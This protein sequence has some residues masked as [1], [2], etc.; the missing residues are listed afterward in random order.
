MP[1]SSPKTGL[2]DVEVIVVGAGP[3]GLMLA[4][5][6]CLAGVRPLVLERRAGPLETLRA[7]GFGGR[8]VQLLRYRGLLQQAGAASIGPIHTPARL[9]FGDLHVDFS[10]LSDPPM[11]G[12]RLPQHKLERL[13][14][15]HARHL[16]AE[17]RRGHEVVGLSRQSASVTAEVNGPAG[18]HRVSGRYLVGCDGAH[19]KVRVEAGISFPGTTYPQVNRL[20]Q[21]TMPKSVRLLDSGELDVPGLGRVRANFTRTDRGVFAIGP[22]SSQA[23]LIQT[24]EDEAAAVDDAAPMTLTEL[25]DSI[26]RVIGVDVPLGEPIRLSRYQFQARQAERY[27]DGRVLVA[28]DA[29]HVFPA[30]GVGISVGMLDAVNL[31]WK[32]AGKIH[33]WA[34]AGLL[35]S[36]HDE[37]HFAGARTMLHT[38]AQVALRRGT[39]SAADALRDLFLELLADEQPLRRIGA[40]I[41]GSDVCY[42]MRHSNDHALT[43]AFAPDLRLRTEHGATS[44]AVLMRAARPVFIDLADRSELRNTAREWLPR[45]DVHTARTVHRPADAM[46][47]RP[48]AHIAWAATLGEPA[49]TATV[50]LR[51][52]LCSWFGAPTRPV[53]VAGRG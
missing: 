41:A 34:P 47:I 38:Q 29:A 40:L 24:T 3:T 50:G 20:G 31:A 2:H 32:L 42:R 6:L 43:G 52:A 22:L 11:Q 53:Q 1:E 44:V 19:S 15:E 28:G 16:G 9:P 51:E 46:L 25:R 39:D 49:D 35:D 12:L 18:L 7:N 23:L 30:T 17:V 26:L 33:G 13:L 37:R 48:D 36:Y 5:E 4:A 10:P 27:R 21:L 8:S 45:I 14:D